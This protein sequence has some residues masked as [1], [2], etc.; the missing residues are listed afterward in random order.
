MPG[1]MSFS[2]GQLMPSTHLDAVFENVIAAVSQLDIPSTTDDVVR[3]LRRALRSFLRSDLANAMSLLTAP[4]Q[5]PESLRRHVPEQSEG[6]R[7]AL[8]GYAGRRA[9]QWSVSTIELLDR[10]RRDW[11]HLVTHFELQP[12]A[13]LIQISPPLGDLH[14]NGRAVCRLLFSDGTSL[15]YKPRSVEAEYV[16][17][18]VLR[19]LDERGCAPKFAVCDA[20]PKVGYGWTRYVPTVLCE[21]ADE[22]AAYYRRQGGFLALFW[23]FGSYDA[24]ADNVVVSRAH[25]VWIDLECISHPDLSDIYPGRTSFPLWLRESM[26]ATAMVL[27][28]T[29]S[30]NAVHSRMTTGLS[31]SSAEDRSRVFNSDGVLHAPFVRAVVEGFQDVYRW[32]LGSGRLESWQHGPLSL[33]RTLEVRV[34]LRRTSIYERLVKLFAV[35]PENATQDLHQDI[36]RLLREGNPPQSGPFPES[37]VQGDL[38]ALRQGDIPYWTA[39]FSS[40]DLNEAHGACAPDACTKSCLDCIEQRL[41]R[42][43]KADCECQSWLLESFLSGGSPTGNSRS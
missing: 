9:S 3:S 37:I 30:P 32:F 14:H 27:D 13:H 29:D 10:L 19:W 40:R 43:S 42:M 24:I 31:V 11:A 22:I 17:S 16:F 4:E 1:R 20:C 7:G 18:T 2:P 36:S 23:M 34:I 5:V 41:V 15:I 35:T 39:S 12:D 33:C 28:G 21:T 6:V 38:A 26:L 25:P 8:E